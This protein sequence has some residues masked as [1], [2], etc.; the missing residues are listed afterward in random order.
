MREIGA[1]LGGEISGHMFFAENYYGFDDAFLA[2]GKLLQIL[3]QSDQPFS[4]LLADLPETACTPEIKS[5]CADDKKFAV[6]EALTEHFTQLYD[7]I[8][9][10]GVRINFDEQSWGA[11]R[12]SNTSPNLTIRFEAPNK[13]RLQEIVDI[14]LEQLRQYP[15]VDLWWAEQRFN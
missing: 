6:V 10:D 13:E 4:A 9:I 15:E 5:G 7:C 2:A 12:C 8:T 14:M 1:P 11:I 3:S